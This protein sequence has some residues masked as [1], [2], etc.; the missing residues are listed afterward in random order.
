MIDPADLILAKARA[1]L[2]AASELQEATAVRYPDAT[3]EL[4]SGDD[5]AGLYLIPIV[6]VRDTEEVA[7]IVADRLLELQV[8][9]GLS[10]YVFPI[11]PLARVLAAS[12]PD[13]GS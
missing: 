2:A 12:T 7:E 13:A 5:P 10:V 9:E 6:D 8:D 4:T 11:R 1:S 3:F